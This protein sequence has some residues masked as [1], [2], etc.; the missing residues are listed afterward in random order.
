M[1]LGWGSVNGEELE[2][3]SMI[4]IGMMLRDSVRRK[5]K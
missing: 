5:V 1:E 2:S 4:E 3:L